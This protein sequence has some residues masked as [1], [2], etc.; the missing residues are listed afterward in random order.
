[1]LT[2]YSFP[3]N[4]KIFFLLAFRAVS[5]FGLSFWSGIC[6]LPLHEFKKRKQLSFSHDNLAFCSENPDLI[7]VTLS[8][9]VGFD[10]LVI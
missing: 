1:M 9:L 4:G 8:S 5:I 10:F 2:L 6:G 3:A 7:M